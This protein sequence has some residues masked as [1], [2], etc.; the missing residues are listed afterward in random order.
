MIS[1]LSL[2]PA[3]IILTYAGRYELDMLFESVNG[4]IKRVEELLEKINTNII[5]G[6]SPI[7]LEEHFTG[8]INGIS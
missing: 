1:P 2:A 8:L 3:D 5:K 4:S 6:D 7:R